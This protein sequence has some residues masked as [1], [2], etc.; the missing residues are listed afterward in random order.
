M[1]NTDDSYLVSGQ[2]A[3]P[4]NVRYI[5][6][7]VIYDVLLGCGTINSERGAASVHL[8]SIPVQDI[9][10]VQQNGEREIN[11]NRRSQSAVVQ[12]NEPCDL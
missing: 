5:V 3:C 4:C 7:Y 8:L 10:V 2:R 12:R 6:Q 9:G 1:K 11:V